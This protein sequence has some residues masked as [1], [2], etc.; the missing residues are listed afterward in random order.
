MSVFRN[1][2]RRVARFARRPERT[3]GE[4][5]NRLAREQI[6]RIAGGPAAGAGAR[7]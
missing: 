5:F 2:T 6:A 3:A 1:L 7:H 4:S